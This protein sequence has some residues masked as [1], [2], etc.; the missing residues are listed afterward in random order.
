[1]AWAF[2]VVYVLA[3]LW[4]FMFF[5]AL[6]FHN[7]LFQII[8]SLSAVGVGACPGWEGDSWEEEGRLRAFEYLKDLKT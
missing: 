4:Y 3:G 5:K 7:A 1:M 6:D 8:N 2:F